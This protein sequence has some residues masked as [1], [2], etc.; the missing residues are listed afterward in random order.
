MPLSVFTKISL[1]YLVRS[2]ARMVSFAL[3]LLVALVIA[4]EGLPDV[5]AFSRG[6]IVSAI[7]FVVMIAGL[8]VGWWREL[9]GA[10]L[11][12]GGFLGFMA[13]EYAA[14]GDVGNERDIHAVPVLGS[15]LLPLLAAHEETVLTDIARGVRSVT[16]GTA[17]SRVLG[18]AREQVFAALFGATS[19]TDAFNA[20]FRIP[21]L[22]RDLFAETALSQAFIPVLTSERK[23]GKEAENLLASN[24]FNTLLVVVGAVTVAGI[25][26]SP[27]LAGFIAAGFGKHPEKLAL[28][29]NLTAIMFPFLLF[30]ALAAWAMSYLNTE[31]SFFT[32]SVA[33]AFF[34]VFSILVPLGLFGY[35]TSR[36][37]DPIYGAAIGVVAGRL[38]QFAVQL[39]RL[40][41]K[42]FRYRLYLSF[43]D[44]EFRRVM[45]LFG[46]V[47]IG[48]AGA[49]INFAVNTVLVSYLQD[50]SMTWLNYAFRIMHS[51][52]RALRHRRRDGGAAGP[53]AARRRERSPRRPGD[54]VRF[55]QDGRSSSRSR[56]PSRSPSSPI[57]SRASSISTGGSPPSDTAAVAQALLL[58]VL[59]V[60]F[61][62][63]L[64]NVAAVFYAYQ[65]REDADVRE[66]RLDR[67]ERR[68]QPRPDAADGFPRV[69]ALHDHRGDCEHRDPVLCSCRARV[70]RD[71]FSALSGNTS[72][73]WRAAAAA[74]GLAGWLLDRYLFQP[75]GPSFWMRLASVVVSGGAAL[76]AVLLRSACLLRVERGER[77]S[78]EIYHR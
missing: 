28:T 23:K 39:P 76:L 68:S 36:G 14:S 33:P 69:S 66:L 47:A 61:M 42:G 58:Y 55:P 26:F 22:L 19:S 16:I 60:P 46:P 17:V 20:A 18:L 25:V 78:E 51:A 53:F 52:A 37:G 71:R 73:R 29:G 74:G 38:M 35:Y 32:P 9:A 6:E 77:L 13:S 27:Q 4:G 31:G 57:R 7:M 54:D 44:P 3:F 56:H 11:I 72:R 62:S 59:G 8:G 65:G 49:R 48:L 50:G 64:R 34:D 5:R 41:R 75:L 63:G 12:V 10:I 43:R 15:A 40:F 70:G 45:T 21:N 30:I 67:R 24:I 1:L 2:I